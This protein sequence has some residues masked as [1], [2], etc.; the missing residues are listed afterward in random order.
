MQA[1]ERIT[2]LDEGWRERKRQICFFEGIRKEQEA[3]PTKWL[4]KIKN[5][6]CIEFLI[7]KMKGE[8]KGKNNQKKR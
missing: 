6:A 4:N 2:E 1:S 7:C 8:K 5:T 3:S